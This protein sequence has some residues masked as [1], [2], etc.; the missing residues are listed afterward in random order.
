MPSRKSNEAYTLDLPLLSLLHQAAP[1]CQAFPIAADPA[2]KA[3]T[4]TKGHKWQKLLTQGS[5]Q[6]MKNAGWNNSPPT[7]PV[8][9]FQTGTLQPGFLCFDGTWGV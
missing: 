6:A 1:D 7:A 5:A 4:I 9:D 2:E 8:T 3:E